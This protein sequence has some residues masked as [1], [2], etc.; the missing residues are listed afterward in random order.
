ME[1][2]MPYQPIDLLKESENPHLYLVHVG[3][4]QEEY[5][6]TSKL[7]LAEKEALAKTIVI[8]ARDEEFLK[9]VRDLMLLELNADANNP[10]RSGNRLLGQ[11]IRG[12]LSAKEQS[13]FRDF[14]AT[15]KPWGNYPIPPVVK[16]IWNVIK[17]A[18]QQTLGPSEW[19][20]FMAKPLKIMPIF[21]YQ[22]LLPELTVQEF[23]QGKKPVEL[24]TDNTQVDS[25][26][27]NLMQDIPVYAFAQAKDTSH[28][29]QQ[30]KMHIQSTNWPVGNYL[31]FKGGIMHG[32]QR[33]PHRIRDI[34]HLIE[35]AE[36]KPEQLQA[37]YAEIIAT[38]KQAIDT[39]RRGRNATTTD[40]YKDVFNHRVLQE[41]YSFKSLDQENVSLLN[42]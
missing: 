19:T 2:V 42:V 9:I 29:L 16:Q 8:K 3:L 39:P 6:A 22:Q 26:N 5:N 13:N 28:H 30:I 31:L 24:T 7:S 21:Y 4:S 11:L 20:E 34:L 15:K 25:F 10:L 41:D 36:Q 17:N 38:A 27:Q 14:Y 18:A 32:K 12:Y 1:N 33:V 35:R 40:F 23:N 37:I